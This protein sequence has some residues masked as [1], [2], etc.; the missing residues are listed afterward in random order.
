MQEHAKQRWH[1]FG[2]TSA[3]TAGWPLSTARVVDPLLPSGGRFV[4]HSRRVERFARR[5]TTPCFV[6]GE[7]APTICFYRIINAARPPGLLLS[8]TVFYSESLKSP[9]GLV[10]ATAA[11]ASLPY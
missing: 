2:H 8:F 3:P 7:V 11:L 5:L 10:C 6:A 9:Y 4:P 1:I